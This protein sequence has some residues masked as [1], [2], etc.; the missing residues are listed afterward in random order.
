MLPVMAPQPRIPDGPERARSPNSQAIHY[1]AGSALDKSTVSFS[2]VLPEGTP[3]F[4]KRNAMISTDFFAATEPGADIG[5]VVCTSDHSVED[6][7][8]A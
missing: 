5:I 4:C 6:F 2:G 7:F 8:P 3:F 1:F